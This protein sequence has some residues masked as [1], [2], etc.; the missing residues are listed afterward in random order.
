M[1]NDLFVLVMFITLKIEMFYIYLVRINYSNSL[2][3]SF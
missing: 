1:E 3:L 2:Y